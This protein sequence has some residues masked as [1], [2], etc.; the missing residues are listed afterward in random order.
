MSLSNCVLGD[1]LNNIDLYS[2]PVGIC[3]CP[4]FSRFSCNGYQMVHWLVPVIVIPSQTYLGQQ[5]PEFFV[6]DWLSL[7]ENFSLTLHGSSFHTLEL[8]VQGGNDYAKQ[9]LPLPPT[10]IV[11]QGSPCIF[12]QCVELLIKKKSIFITQPWASCHFQSAHLRM[13]VTVKVKWG[14]LDLM[15]LC[16]DVGN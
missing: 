6:W 15:V 14:Q 2:L 1:R 7:A 11:F 3:K 9:W 10:P 8:Q 5:C 13:M 16:A 12:L 4:G